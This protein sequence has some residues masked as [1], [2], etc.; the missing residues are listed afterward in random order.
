MEK[1]FRVWEKV[2]KVMLTDGFTVS[3]NGSVSFYWHK[4]PIHSANAI[5][6]QFTGL[7]DKNG[8]E[9][10]EGDI[11]L[12]EKIFSAMSSRGTLRKGYP[13]YISGYLLVE[14]GDAKFNFKFLKTIPEHKEAYEQK[15]YTYAYCHY[16]IWENQQEQPHVELV[17]NI[18]ES[19]ELI[20]KSPPT[21]PQK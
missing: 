16:S 6:M 20:S 17:G 3:P 1:K 21:T 8:N 4:L 2:Q 10:Y 11:L 15:M 7:K 18:Y 19:P 9:I 13:K 14:W 5:L 12:C